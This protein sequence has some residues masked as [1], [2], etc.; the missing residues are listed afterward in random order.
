MK[1]YRNFRRR[2]SSTKLISRVM[3]SACLDL[4]LSWVLK[5][6]L[7]NIFDKNPARR[8]WMRMSS[9]LKHSIRARDL[10]DSSARMGPL[11]R[12]VIFKFARLLTLAECRRAHNSFLT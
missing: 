5:R 11:G 2:S 7:D 10:W 9:R 8:L 3:R 6:Y 12:N 1:N 4:E